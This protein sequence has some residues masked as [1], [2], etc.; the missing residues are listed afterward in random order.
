MKKDPLEINRKIT[1]NEFKD[2]TPG[3]IDNKYWFNK[4]INLDN[5]PLPIEKYEWYVRKSQRNEDYI[6]TYDND[7]EQKVKKQF[8]TIDKIQEHI[9]DMIN[10]E[11][12]NMI[13]VN[14]GRLL[15]DSQKQDDLS[16]DDDI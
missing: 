14:I 4:G 15:N 11:G 5:L 16:G 13:P 12:K 1:I 6:I 10:N 3:N 7:Q 8:K 2:V 9:L